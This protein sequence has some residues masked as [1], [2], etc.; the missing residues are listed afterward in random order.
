MLEEYNEVNSLAG[1]AALVTGAGGSIGRAIG[2]LF[3]E[4]GAA[5]AVADVDGDAASGVGEELRGAGGHAVGLPCDVT[6]PESTVAAVEETV[7]AFGRLDV[8]VNCAA[9]EVPR[10]PAVE[11]DPA[12]WRLTLE[13]NLTGSF[14]L[15]R[16]AIPRMVEQGRGSVILLASHYAHVATAGLAAYCASKGGVV[17]LA[18]ALALEHA[19]DNVRVNTLSPGA[20]SSERL[21]RHYGTHEAAT[22]ALAPRHPVGRLGRAEEV[23]AAAL[24]LAGDTCGFMTGADLRVDG[25]YTTA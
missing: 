22:A 12:G 10:S 1:K 25:G 17:Q 7:A 21:R 6:S 9:A 20:I 11:L 5:V 13:V 15:C 4:R 3:S 14:L 18:R 19:R 2:R 16:A 8:M 24:F 23:A